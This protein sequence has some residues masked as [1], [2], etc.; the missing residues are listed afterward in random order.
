MN[1]KDNDNHDEEL[2]KLLNTINKT[3]ENWVL[4]CPE[5]WLWIHNRW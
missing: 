1:K 4:K 5:Q 2:I 3:L